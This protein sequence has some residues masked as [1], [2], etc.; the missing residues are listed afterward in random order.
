MFRQLPRPDSKWVWE[1]QTPQPISTGQIRTEKPEQC[2][3]WGKPFFFKPSPF[4][5]AT[6]EEN[7]NGRLAQGAFPY[8]LQEFNVYFTDTEQSFCFIYLL[9]IAASQ[10]HGT[11]FSERLKMSRMFQNQILQILFFFFLKQKH[12][13]VF[14]HPLW[15][16]QHANILS[17]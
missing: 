14:Q 13:D 7:S 10:C 5:S 3:Q 8:E 17:T 9:W 4:C 1:Q 6:T 15:W 16:A 11:S 2:Y 12:F